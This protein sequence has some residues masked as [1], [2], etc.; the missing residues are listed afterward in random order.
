M[1]TY[2]VLVSK[3]NSSEILPEIRVLILRKQIFQ[4]RLGQTARKTF[5]AEHVRNRLRLALLQLPNLFFHRS[6]RNQSISVDG[7]RLADAMRAIDGLR[8]H[9][10]VP[11]RIVE[12]D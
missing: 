1:V 3:D 11:P 5:F 8:F 4:I 2:M 6:R 12:H 7:L 9:G 10:R